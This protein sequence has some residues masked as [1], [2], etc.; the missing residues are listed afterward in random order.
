MSTHGKVHGFDENF[1]KVKVPTMEQVL[2]KIY[3]V[4]AIYMSV[5]PTSPASLFGGTWERIKG[6]ALGG[7]NEEDKDT[8]T[9]TSFNQSAGKTIGSKWLQNHTHLLRHKGGSEWQV[10]DAYVEQKVMTYSPSNAYGT[11]SDSTGNGDAQ[12]IQP[13]MLV[14]IWKRVS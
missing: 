14:Y 1:C 2:A 5:S 9:K 11:E 4:G 8:N 10:S 3:P 6:Y 7:I 12:N 13:T